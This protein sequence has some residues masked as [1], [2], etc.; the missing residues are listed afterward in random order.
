ML[1]F[2]AV[3][4]QEE[5]LHKQKL[6]TACYI[7]SE[8]ISRPQFGTETELAAKKWWVLMQIKLSIWFYVKTKTQKITNVNFSV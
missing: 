2:S 8:K 3:K 6:N 5:P 4:K 1:H 7:F